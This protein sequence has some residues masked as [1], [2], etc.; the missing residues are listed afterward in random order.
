MQLKNPV[1]LKEIAELINAKIIGKKNLLVSGLNEIHKV[2][3]GDLMFVDHL[4]Y[5]QKA[6]HSAATVIIINKALKAP[7]GKALL[8]CDAPFEAYEQLTKY[9]RPPVALSVA[10]SESANI[11]PSTTIE[12]NVIIG[13]RVK[14]GKNCHIHAQVVIRDHTIIGDKV[15][16]HSGAIIGGDAFYFNSVAGCYKKWHSC[17]R[18]VIANEVEIGCNTTVDKGVSGDTII[19]KG[20]KIDNLCQIGHGVVIGKNCLL[21]AQA[22]VAGKAI[23]G[24]NCVIYGQ[25]GVSPRVRLGSDTVLSAQSGVSKSLVGGKAYFGSPAG[26][27]RQKYKEIAAVKQL[28]D[29]LKEHRKK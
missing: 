26:E 21:G 5:Y 16:I 20:T 8:L 27:I 11:H 25:A 18:V 29:F 6:L 23:I 15:I 3:P 10:I 4:K 22:G 12:P 24:D 2:V 13:N 28:P 9:Y 17:G 7:K 14:I 1:P 19:G